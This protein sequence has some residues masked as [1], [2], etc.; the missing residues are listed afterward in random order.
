MPDYLARARQTQRFTFDRLGYLGGAKDCDRAPFLSYLRSDREPEWTD[1][2]YIATQLGADAAL[3]RVFPSL[4]RCTIHKAALFLDLM[5]DYQSGGGYLARGRP[6]ASLF[7]RPDKYCDDHGHTGLMLIDAFEVTGNPRY[8]ARA[9]RA[10]DFLMSGRVWDETFG[11]GF[12]WN[13]RRGDTIEGKPA[14]T[15]GLAADLFAELYGIT[16]EPVYRQWAL[17]AFDWLEATL[18]DPEANLYRWSIHFEDLGRRRGQIVPHR[19]FNYDQAI[20]IEAVLAL[21]RHV[22]PDPA[23]LQRAVSLAENLET[24]FWHGTEGGFN[25]EHGIEHV[26]AIYS[27]WLTPSLLALHKVQPDERWLTLARHNVDAM[28]SYL[29]AADGGYYKAARVENGVWVL[30]RTRD[31]AANAG[32]QRAQALLASTM[33]QSEPRP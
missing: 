26:M 16:G 6:D 17:R 1:Q 4:G 18:Y 21:N 8:L 15:N 22:T 30:D 33:P 28:N 11:G 23:Y 13:N 2:W 20:I 10:A 3:L 31:T 19:F 32:M 24:A 9:R 5:W 14:Q 27:S 29:R 12:W 7:L 25:L